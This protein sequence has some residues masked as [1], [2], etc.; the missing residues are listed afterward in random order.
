M[1]ERPDAVRMDLVRNLE[2]VWIDLPARLREGARTFADAGATLGYFGEPARA[3]VSEGHRMLDALA[4]MVVDLVL[5]LE[6]HTR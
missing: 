1:A 2:P 3:S 5:S 6:L 4:K